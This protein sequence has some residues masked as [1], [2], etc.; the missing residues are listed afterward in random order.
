MKTL[1]P[2]L[3]CL[4]LGAG[5]LPEALASK[6]KEP[7]TFDYPDQRLPGSA[8]ATVKGNTRTLQND[9]LSFQFDVTEG[10]VANARFDIPGEAGSTVVVDEPFSLIVD[11]KPMASLLGWAERTSKAR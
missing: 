10:R 9:L 1:L 5:F 3:G 6:S 7:V 4:A 2:L 8:K 11:G